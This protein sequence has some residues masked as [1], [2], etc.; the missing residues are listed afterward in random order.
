MGIR[1]LCL[2]LMVLV[3]PLGWWTWIF[4]AGAIFL[5][6]LAVV[7]ANAGEDARATTTVERPEQTLDASAPAPPPQQSS[8]GVIR[9]EETRPQDEA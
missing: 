1:T 3:Q 6:Y 9:I 8:P 5:P 4:A 2:L 7:A